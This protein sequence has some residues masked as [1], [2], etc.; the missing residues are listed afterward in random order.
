[1]KIKPEALD[2]GLTHPLGASEQMARGQKLGA[3]PECEIV[4]H[5]DD[6]RA[7][8]A[9]AVKKIGLDDVGFPGWHRPFFDLAPRAPGFI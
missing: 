2:D 6:R 4:N 7:L 9:R 5:I 8:D 1:M 3:H